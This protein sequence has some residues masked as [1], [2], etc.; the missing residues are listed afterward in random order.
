MRKLTCYAAAT[1]LTLNGYAQ[2]LVTF[3]NIGGQLVTNF[4]TGQ[5]ISVGSTFLA[6][7]YYADDGITDEALFVQLGGA[8][9]FGPRLGSFSAG[10]RTAPTPVAGG[11]GM[12]QVRA[13]EA[14]FGMTYEQALVAPPIDDRT[15][16]LGK[17]IILRIDTATP[18]DKI[19]SLG[20]SGFQGFYVGSPDTCIP[21]PAP[22]CVFIA[23]TGIW[24]FARQVRHER[25]RSGPIPPARR[26]AKLDSIFVATMI[27]ALT[28]SRQGVS[29]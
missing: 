21:E 12:F 8:A 29:Q 19:S 11:F 10:L 15:A 25:A 28:I 4:C 24:I 5:P 1:L 13:W 17:S 7:L 2:G 3:S 6:A 18:F 16:L 14:D 9:A 27:A 26:I 20:A 22:I 23:I